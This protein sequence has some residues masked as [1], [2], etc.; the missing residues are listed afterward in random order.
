M[1]DYFYALADFIDKQLQ[2]NEV[3]SGDTRT[4]YERVTVLL[5]V[6]RDN[7]L[8]VPDDPYLL[9]ATEI[10]SGE[11]I[12]SHLRRLIWRLAIFRKRMS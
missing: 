12:G 5:S 1:Q 8:H 4:D 3:Y 6:L 10:K 9:Y 2:S 11:S 7:L